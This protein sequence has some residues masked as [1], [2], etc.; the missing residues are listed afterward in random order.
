MI[1]VRMIRL[2]GLI[3]LCLTPVL[4]CY[5]QEQ[6]QNPLDKS[7]YNMQDTGTSD[8]EYLKGQDYNAGTPGYKLGSGLEVIKVGGLNI[9]APKGSKIRRRGSLI[10][11]EDPA[12]YLSRKFDDIDKRFSVLENNQ[13]E[14]TL[15]LQRIEQILEELPQ[16]SVSG[17]K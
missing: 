1:S 2:A 4:F 7:D 17:K 16:R 3:A 6:K 15:Q 11:L 12:E 5:A 9:L 8:A 13:H 14:M 10:I